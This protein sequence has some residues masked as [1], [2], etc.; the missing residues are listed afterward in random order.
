ML[1]ILHGE[2]D[3]SLHQALERIKA[4][5][6]SPDM[7]AV[8]T[9]RLDGEHLILSELKDN[10]NVVPFL[11]PHRLIIIE[12]LLGRFEP[13]GKRTRSYKS[14]HRSKKELGEWR[15]LVTCIQQMP[16]ST[17]LVLVD[18]TVKK[19]NPLFQK[20]SP[21]AEVEPFRLLRGDK[22][23]NWI[24]KQ[25]NREGGEIAP[26]AIDLLA[27]LIGGN[28]WTMNNEIQK[29]LLYSQDRSIDKQDVARL[30]SYAREANIFALVDA[31]VEGKTR[32]AQEV[33]HQLYQDGDSSTHI[34]AMVTRQFRLIALVK[35]MKPELSIWQIQKKLG[36]S[37]DYALEKTLAQARFYTLEDIRQAY[38]KLLETD[39]AIK[40]RG[41]NDQ[42]AL[43]L[44][45]TELSA[46]RA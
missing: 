16:A 25:V 17:V 41:Y 12:G 14:A 37:S 7:L 5:L 43:E 33:L 13:G 3:F 32:R 11:C 29:L 23:K 20:I 42:L 9:T 34:L 27:E 22:L 19:S 1:Y 24:Q 6:G 15:D 45:V 4:G 28:L 35:D 30:V 26:E 10:C 44:L 18:V 8:N 31:V 36:L 39:L 2:D 38:N 21:L 40:T 46:S